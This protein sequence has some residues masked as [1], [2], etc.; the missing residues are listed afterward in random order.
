MTVHGYE[1][2]SHLGFTVRKGRSEHHFD[3]YAEALHF[4]QTHYGYTLIYKVNS[5]G[6]E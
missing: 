1:V 2:L 6:R 4:L 3:T 5:R